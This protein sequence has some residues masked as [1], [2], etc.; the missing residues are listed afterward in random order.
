[1]SQ[2]Q[3]SRSS[4]DELR[5]E[6]EYYSVK[7]FA[8]AV[9]ALSS[10]LHSNATFRVTRN[11][12]A[13]EGLSRDIT[14]YIAIVLPEAFF[15]EYSLRGEALVFDVNLKELQQLL[16]GLKRDGRVAFKVFDNRVELGV[17][18]VKHV[19]Y[20]AKPKDIVNPSLLEFKH[21]VKA[22]VDTSL[23][24]KIIEFLSETGE[25]ISDS[26][27]EFEIVARVNQPHLVIRANRSKYQAEFKLNT[28][29]EVAEDSVGR[30]DA[31][32]LSNFTPHLTK[33]SDHATLMYSP[34]QPLELIADTRDM[35]VRYLLASRI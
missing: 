20:T 26:E 29:V 22:V 16:K 11:G 23:L 19:I 21:T 7:A 27:R 13:M 33:L 12:V 10:V 9:G 2:G 17:E 8:R 15:T 31:R 14:Q 5:A 35:I 3:V 24:H 18:G 1:M 25:G 4:V 32:T 30:Y 34:G 6:L 28:N